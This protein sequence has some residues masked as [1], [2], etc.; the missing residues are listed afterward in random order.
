VST[1]YLNA[2]A[3]YPDPAIALHTFF[4]SIAS[5][6]PTGVQITFPNVTDTLDAETGKLLSSGTSA[7]AG[8]VA[9]GGGGTFAAPTGVL[10]KWFTADIVN[11]HRVHGRTFLVPIMSGGA[12]NGVPGGT[13]ITAVTNAASALLA[14]W[15][16]AAIVWAR[17]FKDKLGVKPPRVGS[18]HVITGLNVPPEFVVLRSRRD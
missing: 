7:G 4:S 11:G 5:Q 2:A 18:M 14:A 13:Q 12:N 8:S 17:P 10:V 6:L 16:A 3:S 9:G 1:F 15:G